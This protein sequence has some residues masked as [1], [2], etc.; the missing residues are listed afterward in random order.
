M[1]E[2]GYG[3]PGD[4]EMH[5]TC[6]HDGVM[7]ICGGR[8]DRGLLSDVWILEAN[9]SSEGDAVMDRPPLAWRRRTDLELPRALCSH[10]ATI[11]HASSY[12]TTSLNF[13]HN[14]NLVESSNPHYNYDAFVITRGFSGDG[15]SD[16]V[17][18]IR[19]CDG[20]SV[21][22]G[23]PIASEP[24]R[25]SSCTRWTTVDLVPQL[26][27]RFGAAVCSLSRRTCQH[28]VNNP[29]YLPVFDAAFKSKIN[30]DSIE[31]AS[32]ADSTPIAMLMFGGVCM[33][34]DFGDLHLLIL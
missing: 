22:Q 8:N 5:G 14:D 19:L 28:V 25:S 7:L 34:K 30:S 27:G 20:L 26:E 24:S 10:V 17:I 31:P 6:C 1:G 33:E 21:H 3:R 15:I 16:A 11:I 13:K 2:F 4:R 23:S 12:F 29:K 9:N 32:S 18:V